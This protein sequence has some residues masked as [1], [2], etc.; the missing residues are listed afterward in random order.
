MEG[1]RPNQQRGSSGAHRGGSLLLA[2]GF[3]KLVVTTTDFQ[4][5]EVTWRALS[6]N[7]ASPLTLTALVHAYEASFVSWGRHARL[8]P[9]QT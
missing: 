8:V 7:S 9:E 1:L 4:R 5:L 3:E 6:Q 2:A